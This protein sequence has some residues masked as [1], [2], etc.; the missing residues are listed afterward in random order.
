[1]QIISGK[2]ARHKL[3]PPKGKEVTRPPLSRF[4]KA[5]FDTLMP[6]IP[7]GAYLDPFGGT[8]SFAIE[9]LS[10]GAHSATIIEMDRHALQVIQ[11]NLDH[12]G[13]E[14]PVE[15]KNG[16]ALQVIPQLAQLGRQ[17]AIIGLAP[18]YKK[19]LERASIEVVDQ[20]PQLLQE[21]G[22]L[23]LQRPNEEPI[24]PLQHFAFWKERRYGN[25][26]FSYFTLD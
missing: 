25:T 19:G 12:I 21:G 11:A 2:Y 1:M 6:F 22:V 26:T 7:R 16:D 23:F 3:I 13:V 10:R 20:Y 4:R 17:Y 8:G 5:V 9:A 14:E 15:L 18:P 24:P